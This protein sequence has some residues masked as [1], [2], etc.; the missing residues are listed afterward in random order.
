LGYE[1]EFEHPTDTVIGAT[2]V[3][4]LDGSVDF[5]HLLK[6]ESWPAN[7][8]KSLWYF[9]GAMDDYGPPPPFTDHG[10]PQRQYER[11]KAQCI[12]YLQ[13][14]GPLLPKAT[15]N[16][17]NPPGDPIGLNF[18]V[19]H[20]YAPM[21]PEAKGV[22]RF[23]QQ[24]WRANIDPTERYVTSPPGSTA[25]RLKAWGSGYSNLVSGWGLDLYR[26][27]CRE[28]GRHGNGWQTCFSCHQQLPAANGYY[29]LS[30]RQRV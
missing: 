6:W 27:E 12:Q 10:Y 30:P 11:V 17:L 22:R 29:R 28:R 3:N 20:Q 1:Q 7:G 8:P 19:L 5:T 25:A 4:P 26:S 16:A 9:S 21:V 18:S 13:A 23:D 24:F 14:I 2:F 15:T